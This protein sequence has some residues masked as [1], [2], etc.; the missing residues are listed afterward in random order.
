MYLNDYG[1]KDDFHPSVK[2][3]DD[4]NS[5]NACG[6]QKKTFFLNKH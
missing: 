5:T 3:Y 4:T 6:G 1:K 2:R